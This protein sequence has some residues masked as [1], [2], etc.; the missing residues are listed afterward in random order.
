MK[1]RQTQEP[2]PEADQTVRLPIDTKSGTS[3]IRI[4]FTDQRLTAHG[5]LAVWSHFLH[6]KGVRRELRELLPHEP[7]SPNAYEPSDIALGYMGGILCGADKLSRVAWLQSDAAVAQV[8]GIEAVA[9]QSTGDE[10]S[11]AG[12][13]PVPQPSIVIGMPSS[14]SRL[15]SSSAVR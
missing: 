11:V 14:A 3:S 13:E 9:S 7:S 2:R 10:W 15:P 1:R 8:T 4:S 12:L 5:G 6:Q